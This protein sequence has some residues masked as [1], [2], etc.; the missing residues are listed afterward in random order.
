MEVAKQDGRLCG[1]LAVYIGNAHLMLVFEDTAGL[2][3]QDF[4]TSRIKIEK[5]RKEED[6]VSLYQHQA[7]GYNYNLP[8][9]KTL[10]PGLKLSGVFLLDR[11]VTNDLV[12]EYLSV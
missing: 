2:S 11:K 8:K 10:L 4:G 12:V 6:I 7:D 3:L 9:P 5:K 1:W